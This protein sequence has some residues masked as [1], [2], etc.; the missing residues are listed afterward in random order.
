M[1]TQLLPAN[2]AGLSAAA[3]ALS[4]GAL[5][6]IPTETVYGLA[7][8]GLNPQAVAAI[9]AAKN[10]PADN[11]LIQHVADIEGGL[12]LFAHASALARRLMEAFWPGPFTLVLPAAPHVPEIAR[13]GLSTVAVRCPDHSWTR[14]LI[15]RCGFPLA[16]PSANLSGRPSPTT[17]QA[18]LADMDGRIPLVIDGGPC[19]VGVE[20]TVVT[21]RGDQIILL[22][23]GG[24]TPEHLCAITDDV[25]IDSG[26]CAPHDGAAPA[27]SPGM[28]HRHYAPLAQVVLYTGADSALPS[29]I[30]ADYDALAQSGARPVILSGE[31]NGCGSRHHL[32]AG[33]TAEEYAQ[34]LFGL[35]RR[36]DELG[37][38]HI[39]APLP[40]KNGV[41]L[42]L[43]NR[44][45]R[46]ADFNLVT[47]K[48]DD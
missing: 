29:R 20:S 4:S 28:T 25:I 1:K 14:R 19:S 11:P 48:E 46:A 15:A 47:V 7:A 5:V 24:I 3:A 42:A 34:R 16:A 39:L 26:V 13:A 37:Y 27:A 8:N 21:L 9:F 41:S 32:Y 6:G 36:A 30:G 44:L 18:V 31:A 40:A 23:P 17:A 38:S 35:L 45:L 33:G 12:A 10:R 2:E 22:R 43:A